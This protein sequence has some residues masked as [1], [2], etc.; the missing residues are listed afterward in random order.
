MWPANNSPRALST[1]PSVMLLGRKTY[2]GA[3]RAR[4]KVMVWYL[5]VETGP[6]SAASGFPLEKCFF[7]GAPALLVSIGALV[8]AVRIM[9]DFKMA[10]MQNLECW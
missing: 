4:L 3:T 10:R 6:E 8:A 7:E 5:C 2:V 1:N 9:V